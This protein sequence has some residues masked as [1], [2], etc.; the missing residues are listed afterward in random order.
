MVWSAVGAEYGR[1][2]SQVAARPP[3]PIRVPTLAAV[4][5]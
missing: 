1:L 5:A 4:N 3:T 2:F